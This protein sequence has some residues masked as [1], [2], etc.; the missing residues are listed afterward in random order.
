VSVTA[1]PD[2]QARAR[3]EAQFHARTLSYIPGFRDDGIPVT[4]L[5]GEDA[6]CPAGH[7]L[8]ACLVNQLARAHRRIV[9][10]GVDRVLACPWPFTASTLAQATLETARMI[11]PFIEVSA[12]HA[13][14]ERA[15][16]GGLVIGIGDAPGAHL[17]LGADGFIAEL[18]SRTRI[19]DRPASVWG[20]LLAACFGA[21]VAFH[22]ALGRRG[23]LPVGRFSLWELGRPDGADGP[24]LPGPLDVGRVLQAG[25]GAVGCALDLACV[26]VG[27]A[28]QLTIL[29]GDLVEISNLNRQALFLAGDCG[30]PTGPAANKAATVARRLRAST[31]A[32]ILPA[33]SWYGEEQSIVD[34]PYDVVLALANDRG[35]RGAL[36]ARQPTVLMHATT[37][38]NWQ[39]QVHRHVAGHD[40][41]IDCRIP[42]QAAPM[43]CSS[44][45]VQT[46]AGSRD[47]ALPFLSMTAGVLLAAQLVRLQHGAILDDPVNQTNVDLAEPDPLHI[48]VLCGCRIACRTRLPGPA[49]R[50]V[51]ANSRWLA[52][53]NDP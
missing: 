32:E 34:A 13:L 11:N 44:S 3:F 37:S 6:H 16:D 38:S 18:G 49:R 20:A 35:V 27:L 43:R 53:D 30:W 47:A 48:Q 15:R 29:D 25:A 9:L 50:T 5:L 8:A 10:T 52:L 41:C 26:I 4:V 46:S 28:G 23:E 33:T 12:T 39:A 7:A 45:E 1:H 24:A 51:D 42:P 22:W 21:S 17:C 40:D 31:R 14:G 36:Q 19:V 2:D